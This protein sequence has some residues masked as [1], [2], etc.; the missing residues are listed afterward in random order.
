VSKRSIVVVVAVLV[1]AGVLWFGEQ[2][3][4]NAILAM[5]GRGR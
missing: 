3:L 2:A 1:V 5:H 4:W